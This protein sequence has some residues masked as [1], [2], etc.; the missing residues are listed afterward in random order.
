ML[1]GVAAA[2]DAIVGGKKIFLIEVSALS[3]RQPARFRM[4]KEDQVWRGARRFQSLVEFLN[5]RLVF[6]AIWLDDDGHSEGFGRPST[7]LRSVTTVFFVE[8][9]F[10]STTKTS[11]RYHLPSG[12]LPN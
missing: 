6:P 10:N 7:A 4:A 2:H 3:G 8:R 11:V 5:R 1:E 12:I 9:Y